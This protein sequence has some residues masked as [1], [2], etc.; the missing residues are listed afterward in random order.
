[1]TDIFKEGKESVMPTWAKFV[2]PGDAAQG[3]YIGKIVGQ[4]N[5]F[6]SEQVI[7]QLLQEDGTVQNVGF[8]LNK[9]FMIRDMEQVK[10][11]QIIGFKYKGTVSVKNRAGQLVNVKDYALFQDPKIVNEAWLKE[12]VGNMPEVTHSAQAEPTR[13]AND[14]G[15]FNDPVEPEGDEDVDDV[16]FSSDG[17]LTNEDKLAVIEKLAKD[18]LGATD[19]QTAKDKVMEALEIAFIPVNFSKIIEALTAM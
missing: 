13:A 3:T 12:N 14:F 6:G 8:G 7:Y 1:M 16:P 15:A 19:A 11:G 10:F 2:N 18:K 5:G 9:K 4:I 17:S